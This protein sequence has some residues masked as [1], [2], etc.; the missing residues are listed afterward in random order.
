VR[1][2]VI[3]VLMALALTVVPAAGVLAASSADVSVTADPIYVSISNGPA[4]E[5]LG[6]VA[7]NSITWAYGSTPNDP[8]DDATCTF[9]VSN[10][11]EVDVNIAIK[12]IDFTGGSGW[13]LAGTAGVD[14]VVMKAGYEGQ[15]HSAMITLTTSSQA[16]ISSLTVGNDIDWEFNL[17][18][19]TFTDGVLKTG[20]ITLTASQA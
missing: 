8:L 18:T 7:E 9:T 14:T 19:G 3:A 16:F 17:E 15:N 2:T 11:G 20:G 4:S 1:K 6:N 13:T 12:A 10:D 5:A